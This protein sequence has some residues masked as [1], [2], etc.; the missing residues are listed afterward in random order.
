M[1]GW[2]TI[3]MACVGATVGE[4]LWA[5]NLDPGSK[6]P[7]RSVELGVLLGALGTQIAKIFA[8]YLQF[9]E[10]RLLVSSDECAITE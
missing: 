2:L 8:D 4:E 9:C 3:T 6:V 1:G 10:L 5:N 7:W